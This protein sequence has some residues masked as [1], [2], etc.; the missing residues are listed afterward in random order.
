M[1]LVAV[2]GH[3]VP[4]AHRRDLGQRRT[5]MGWR[6]AARRCTRTA[7]AVRAMNKTIAMA[8]ASV[9]AACATSPMAQT[10]E[11][12]GDAVPPVR[13]TIL[14][15]SAAQGAMVVGTTHGTA[16]VRHQAR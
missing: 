12:I 16:T 15:T 13:Q 11:R 2:R 5:R 14:P 3:D 9:L 10:P 7:I 4:F 6:E 1:R 8:A